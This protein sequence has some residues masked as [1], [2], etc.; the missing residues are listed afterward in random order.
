MHETKYLYIIFTVQIQTKNRKV[1]K[2]LLDAVPYDIEM[3]DP[4]TQDDT[5]DSNCNMNG[6]VGDNLHSDKEIFDQSEET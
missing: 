1:T 2:H 4:M 5:V 6:L 3:F